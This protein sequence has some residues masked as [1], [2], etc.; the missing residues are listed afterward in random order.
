MRKAFKAREDD[1]EATKT[2][3]TKVDNDMRW[4][5]YV[6]RLDFLSV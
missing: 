6:F 1:L 2:A 5:Y 3:C 4:V